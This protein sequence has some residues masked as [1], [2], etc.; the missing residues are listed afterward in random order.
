MKPYDHKLR[1]TGHPVCSAIHKPQM[2]ISVSGWVTTS[3]PYC[4]MFF[5]LF[6]YILRRCYGV[7]CIVCCGGVAKSG[8]R[9]QLAVRF[10]GWS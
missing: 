9:W 8:I 4:C 2:G 10:G 7:V 5:V 6:S 3:A 1:R